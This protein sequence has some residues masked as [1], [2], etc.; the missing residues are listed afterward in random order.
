M[1]PGPVRHAGAL[2]QECV[3]PETL[4]LEVMGRDGGTPSPP[5]LTLR[6]KAT[7]QHR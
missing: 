2:P 6:G 4:D 7:S 3:G 1:E 5:G